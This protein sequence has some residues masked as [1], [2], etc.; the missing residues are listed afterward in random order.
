MVI[1]LKLKYR[2]AYIS[3]GGQPKPTTGQRTSSMLGKSLHE[4]WKG[5]ASQA[6]QKYTRE[7]HALLAVHKVKVYRFK[8]KSY[9]ALACTC[10]P[11]LLVQSHGLH[12]D[13]CPRQEDIDEPS[14][15]QAS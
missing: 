2:T 3:T 5:Q 1:K 6:F 11:A 14:Q 10:E 13:Y 9:W 15:A 4:Q 8:G 12:G 7:Q